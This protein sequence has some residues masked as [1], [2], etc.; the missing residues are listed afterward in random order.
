MDKAT[1]VLIPDQIILGLLRGVT[2]AQIHMGVA[3]TVCCN[4]LLENYGSG[5]SNVKQIAERLDVSYPNRFGLLNNSNV[6]NYVQPVYN[7]T[8]YCQEMDGVCGKTHGK[9]SGLDLMVCFEFASKFE[10]LKVMIDLSY[11][12]LQLMQY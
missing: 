4:F 10:N 6:I 12:Y 1:W 7:N 2:G 5:F 9:L 3:K 11:N 8:R